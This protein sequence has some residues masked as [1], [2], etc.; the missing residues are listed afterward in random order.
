MNWQ[1]NVLRLQGKGIFSKVAMYGLPDRRRLIFDWTDPLSS[2]RRSKR[3]QIQ[4]QQY[5]AYTQG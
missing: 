3:R 2:P 4:A 1:Y 5:S